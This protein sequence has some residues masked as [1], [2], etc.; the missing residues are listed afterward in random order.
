M[1]APLALIACALL[2]GSC[3]QYERAG[4]A[5]ARGAAEHEAGRQIYNYRCYFC[6]GYSGDAQTLAARMIEPAPR[7]FTRTPGLSAERVAVVLSHGIPGT[8]MTPFANVLSPGEIDLLARFVVAEFVTAK[9]P[10]TRYHTVQNGWPNHERYAPA[11]PFATGAIALDHP[12]QALTPHEQAGKQ[13]F[14]NSC[15]TCHDRSNVLDIG[16]AWSAGRGAG[17]VTASMQ[18]TKA[19]RQ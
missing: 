7:D 14:M 9:A 10:N 5:S 12:E 4:A 17:T 2:L 1:H 18:P 19:R 13:L 15:I 6:H 16:S 3:G 11:F 8:A